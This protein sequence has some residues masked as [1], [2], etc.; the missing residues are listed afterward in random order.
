M[1][2]ERF[3]GVVYCKAKKIKLSPRSEAVNKLF[4]EAYKSRTYVQHIQLEEIGKVNVLVNLA[5]D[6][7]RRNECM[8]IIPVRDGRRVVGYEL[9]KVI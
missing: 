2:T 6:Y 7:F 5:R 4:T 3:N 8:S 9:T 1:R